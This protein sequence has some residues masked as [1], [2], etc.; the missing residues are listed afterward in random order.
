M[1]ADHYRAVLDHVDTDRVLAL[2]QALIRIPSSTFVITSY[3]IH[4][5]KLY[6]NM[7]FKIVRRRSLNSSAVVDS[8]VIACSCGLLAKRREARAVLNWRE[9]A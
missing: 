9:S 6:D 7:S 3:S 4:Y 2:E 1:V 8:S 5:T